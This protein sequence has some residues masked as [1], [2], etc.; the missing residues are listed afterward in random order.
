MLP[1]NKSCQLGI[2]TA[3]NGSVAIFMGTAVPVMRALR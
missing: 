1:H 2:V 3:E